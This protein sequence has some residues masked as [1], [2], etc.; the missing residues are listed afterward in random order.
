MG[1]MAPT[2]DTMGRGSRPSLAFGEGMRRLRYF[3]KH[4]LVAVSKPCPKQDSRT[5]I[6][7]S[8]PSGSLR[9][10]RRNSG[11][12]RAVAVLQ[13]DAALWRSAP[14]FPDGLVG[15]PSRSAS[16]ETNSFVH[17]HPE[18]TTAKRPSRRR[19]LMLRDAAWRP[20]LSMR[21][22]VSRLHPTFSLVARGDGG[23][24]R[25]RASPPRDSRSGRYKGRDAR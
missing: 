22:T 20:L 8:H 9:G 3:G 18:E 15:K 10:L 7:G 24:C 1:Y 25:H 23:R 2:C 4:G 21:S 11:K 5:G 16:G 13:T 6:A 17:P 12:G 19:S 14:S